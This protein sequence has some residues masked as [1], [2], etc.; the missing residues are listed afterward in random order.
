MWGI[1]GHFCFLAEDSGAREVTGVDV[2]HPTEEFR[3]KKS[4]KNSRIRF[5]EG[6]F[7]DPVIQSEIGVCNV[8]LC[9][10]VLYHVPNPL[11]TILDLRKICDEVLILATAVIPEMEIKNAAVFWPNLDEHERRLW[12]RRLGTQVGITTPYDPSEGYGNWIW[13]LSP[14][15]IVSMLKIA[16]FT[17]EQHKVTSFGAV[18]V[19]RAGEV[20]FTPVSGKSESPLAETFV[21]ARLGGVNRKLWADGKK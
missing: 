14:S 17:V 2:M 15:A 10:G 8:V 11:E 7:H 12:N 3:A 6:D 18:F 16:G 9:S 21:G 5:V 4:S 20:K 13:G 19:C 1:S